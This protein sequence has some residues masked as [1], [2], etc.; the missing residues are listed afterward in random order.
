MAV[1]QLQYSTVLLSHTSATKLI[2][3]FLKDVLRRLPTA[4]Y[5]DMLGMLPGNWSPQPAT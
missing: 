4:S 5:D 1:G 3:K 2:L